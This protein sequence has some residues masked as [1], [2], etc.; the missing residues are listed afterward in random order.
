MLRA[1]ALLMGDALPASD[2]VARF[3]ARLAMLSNDTLRLLSQL[4]P[5][6]AYYF[7]ESRRGVTSLRLQASLRREVINVIQSSCRD[8]IAV[9]RFVASLPVAARRDLACVLGRVSLVEGSFASSGGAAEADSAP[10]V[11]LEEALRGSADEE[12][13]FS[14]FGA[15][16]FLRF[17]F[18]DVIAERLALEPD[19]DCVAELTDAALALGRFAEATVTAYVSST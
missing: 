6:R 2:T 4:P 14:A 13:T 17:D 19:G 8:D 11:A 1:G 16:F 18:A 15:G 7:D 5:V 9:I 12:V 10:T 3:V